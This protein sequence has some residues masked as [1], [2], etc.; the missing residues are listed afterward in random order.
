V[1]HSGAARAAGWGRAAGVLRASALLAALPTVF[2]LAACGTSNGAGGF[3]TDTTGDDASDEGGVGGDATVA[4]T[5]DGGGLKLRTPSGTDAS[6]LACSGTG[7]CTLVPSGCTTSLSGT[8]YDPAGAN[9]LY[10]VVV[11][12]PNDPMGKLP[13]I[14]TG[15]HSCNTC[16]V[17]IGDYVAATVSDAN[18][19]FT[20]K[21]VPATTNVPLVVQTGKWRREVFLPKVTACS[22]TA[23]AAADSRLPRS[24]SEG[25]LPQM[26]LLTGGC[27]DTACFLQNVGIADSEFTSPG[28]GGRL[29]IYQG[30]GGAAFS[31][32]TPGAC[33]VDGCPLWASTASLEPYDIVLLSCECATHDETKPV[34]AKQ[35]LHDW[36]SEGGKVFASHYHYTW[37]QNGPTDF[38]GVAT[39]LGSSPASGSGNFDLD[40]TFPKGMTYS[41][42]LKDVG[43]LNADGTIALTSVAASV[44]TVNPP[45]QRWIYDPTT[46][47]VKYLSFL[48]PIGGLPKA[49]DASSDE[50]PQ[51]CGKAVFTDL[52]MSGQFGA[53]PVDTIPSGCTTGPLTP[54]QKALEFL[55]FDLSA[56]VAPE[57]ETP[58]PP[59]PPTQ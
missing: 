36:L 22:N 35:A 46:D 5:G 8:V 20:L 55:F 58:P 21:N 30:V 11:F 31:N 2:A 54:L 23:V 44:S 25:D 53:S 52:H 32:G 10:N 1:V 7:L 40:T 37:F 13:A 6:G 42:W 49:V 59:P 47:D 57:N 12:V 43:A 56:C 28:A 29:D 9:P 14:Q 15:T 51:Y 27:D 33:N 24:K 41:E 3:D 4:A 18:G 17:S 48:T 45:T 26:A 39:W 38:Q 34:A 16:D 50:G 19:N